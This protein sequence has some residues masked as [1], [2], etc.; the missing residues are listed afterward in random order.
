MQHFGRCLP[1]A[2]RMPVP[3]SLILHLRRLSPALAASF[4]A[5]QELESYVVEVG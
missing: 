4:H 2:K 5:L 1:A 3:E